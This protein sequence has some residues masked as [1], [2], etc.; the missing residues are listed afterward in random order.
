MQ[1]KESARAAGKFTEKAQSE[2]EWVTVNEAEFEFAGY[3]DTQ[4]ESRIL[5]YHKAMSRI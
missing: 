5:A 3:D 1:Q 2:L 4:T